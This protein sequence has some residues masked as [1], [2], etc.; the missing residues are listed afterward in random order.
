MKQITLFV[1]AMLCLVTSNLY[2]QNFPNTY[3]PNEFFLGQD[4]KGI[5]K[6]NRSA[7]FTSQMTWTTL[8]YDQTPFSGWFNYEYHTNVIHRLQIEVENVIGPFIMDSEVTSNV[9]IPVG[10]HKVILRK[11]LTKVNSTVVEAVVSEKVYDFQVKSGDAYISPDEVWNI[12][13]YADEF[14]PPVQGLYPV[15]SPLQHYNNPE[16]RE[17]IAIVKLGEG[18]TELT[19]PLIMVDGVDFTHEVILEP[20]TDRI[21]RYVQAG[22]V[23][24]K[25]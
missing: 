3:Y 23:L 19:R 24:C 13:L 17:A 16:S 5:W 8:P 20:G 1:L 6:I 14:T 25:D 4:D 11:V 18:N 10:R 2:A 15:G 21:I 22:K 12:N 9:S 7:S